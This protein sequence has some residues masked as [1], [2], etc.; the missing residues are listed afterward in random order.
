MQ[1]I[2]TKA[3]E[4]TASRFP[5]RSKLDTL[6]LVRALRELAQRAWLGPKLERTAQW[7]EGELRMRAQEAAQKVGI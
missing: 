2:K 4:A 3:I 7:L 1:T 6:T 5:A